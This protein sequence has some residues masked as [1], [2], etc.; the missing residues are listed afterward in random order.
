MNGIQRALAGTYLALDALGI[1]LFGFVVFC[2]RE[3]RHFLNN[4]LPS[5][6]T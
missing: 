2:V 3:S 6:K 1:V 5:A 4:G